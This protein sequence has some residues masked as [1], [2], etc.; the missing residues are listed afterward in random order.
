[1][2]PA[3][4]MPPI[5]TEPVSPK[6]VASPC[7]PAAAVYAP[8]VRPAPAQAVRSGGVQL[9]RA[10]RREVDHDAAVADAVARGAVAAAADGELGS[11]S[12]GRGR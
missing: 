10:Q 9:E 6:P 5:P 7:S 11:R 4:V 12:R 3:S 1:M 8:A 2:P